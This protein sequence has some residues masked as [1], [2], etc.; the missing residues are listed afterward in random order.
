ML[1]LTRRNFLFSAI[2]LKLLIKDIFCLELKSNSVNTDKFSL[3][4]FLLLFHP[5]NNISCGDQHKAAKYKN[6]SL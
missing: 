1:V 5:G 4:I 6:I 2:C 3:T